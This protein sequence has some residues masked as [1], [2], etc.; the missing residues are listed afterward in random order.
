MGTYHIQNDSIQRSRYFQHQP[1]KFSNG[2]KRNRSSSKRMRVGATARRN[3]SKTPPSDDDNVF[4]QSWLASNKYLHNETNPPTKKKK[5]HRTVKR[6]SEVFGTS[7][8]KIQYIRKKYI[9]FPANVDV[10]SCHR[11]PTQRCFFRVSWNNV[12]TNKIAWFVSMILRPATFYFRVSQGRCNSYVTKT[13]PR[14]QGWAWIWLFYC[15]VKS[16]LCY[17]PTTDLLWHPKGPVSLRSSSS[18]T[19]PSTLVFF[20]GRSGAKMIRWGWKVRQREP[21]SYNSFWR[22]LGEVILLLRPWGLTFFTLPVHLYSSP[23]LFRDVGKRQW[24]G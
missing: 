6:E 19:P 23:N 3:F 7:L 1:K 4:G 12:N 9:I 8:E 10:M 14:S 13:S 21:K 15:K 17:F 20:W 5:R 18:S 16:R 22:F 2:H 24:L 11:S